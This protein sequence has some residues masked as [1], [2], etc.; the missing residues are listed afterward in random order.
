MNGQK[1]ER[2]NHKGEQL[3]LRFEDFGGRILRLCD[4]FPRTFG[5]RH[6]EDQLA[7]AGTN[8]G[9]HYNEAQGAHTPKEFAY[10]IS[11]ALREAREARYWLGVA[12]KAG[13]CDPK[14]DVA[15]LQQ[16]ATEFVAMLQATQQTM[17]RKLKEPLPQLPAKKR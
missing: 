4:T 13:Y 1:A 14:F 8:A 12:E 16:E 6:L 17:R 15:A 11:L 9:A 10:R 7:R 2:R 5:G 3:A